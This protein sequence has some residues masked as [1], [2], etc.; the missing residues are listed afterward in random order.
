MDLEEED[1]SYPIWER[2]IYAVGAGLIIIGLILKYNR[3]PY[4]QYCLLMGIGVLFVSYIVGFFS[5][6][7][8]KDRDELDQI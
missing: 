7:K 8:D 2:I 6:E 4:A 3:L 5:K 1:S